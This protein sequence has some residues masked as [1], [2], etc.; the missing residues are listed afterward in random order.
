MLV[1]PDHLHHARGVLVDLDGTLLTG[2]TLVG[3][4]RELLAMVEGRFV[5]VSNNAEHTP[6]ELAAMLGSLGLD[7]PADRIVLAGT[8]ALELIARDLPQARVMLL[9]SPSLHDFAQALGLRVDDDHPEVV[10]VGR[11][12]RFSYERLRLAANAVRAGAMLVAANPDLTHPG[13][14]GGI[15]PETGAILAAILACTGPTAHRVVGKPEH[16]LFLAGLALLGCAPH[17]AVMIG[18]NIETDGRGAERLGMPFIRV[19]PHVEQLA[20]SR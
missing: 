9:G 6:A 10:V 19:Q 12:R 5:I 11:D 2:E 17:E 13:L 16:T 4:A 18:D 1:D 7:V 3:G 14:A 15:V 20:H 8:L